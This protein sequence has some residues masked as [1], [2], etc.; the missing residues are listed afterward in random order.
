IDPLFASKRDICRRAK[1]FDV[2]CS[3]I[4]D[5]IRE[6]V[7]KTRTDHPGLYSPEILRGSLEARNIVLAVQ[8]AEHV[9]N[10]KEWQCLACSHFFSPIE[11]ASI[12]HCPVCQSRKIA[13]VARRPQPIRGPSAG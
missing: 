2:E 10:A 9:I 13:P 3:S 12:R 7:T 5:V 11:P 8:Y 1:L 6:I 4:P